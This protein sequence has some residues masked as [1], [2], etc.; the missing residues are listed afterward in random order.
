MCV[1]S[2]A[3]RRQKP[4]ALRA[5]AIDIGSNAVRLLVQDIRDT[6]QGVQADKVAYSRVP[7]RLGEEV[8]GSGAISSEKARQLS[9]AMSGYF[10]LMQALDV[11]RHRACATSAMREASNGLAVR[12][13]IAEDTGIYIDCISGEEE[14]DLIFSNFSIHHLDDREDCLFIDVGGGST[15]LTLIRNGKRIQRQSFKVG[16]V[17]MLKG[18]EK[19]DVLDEMQSW[20]RACME[21]HGLSGVQAVGTGGNINQ[22]HKLMVKTVREPVSADELVHWLGHLESLSVE[23]R[24]SRYPLKPDRADVIVPAGRI[25]LKAMEAAGADRILVP[26]VGLADGIVL[27]LFRRSMAE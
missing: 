12:A 26:K 22:L 20:C 18:K 25:Y 23:E 11:E 5:A 10:H 16:S 8:F 6:E 3:S 9:D 13:A 21:S 15:E 1:L 4:T 24:I 14:A 19:S 7:I 17:R 27:D 2:A